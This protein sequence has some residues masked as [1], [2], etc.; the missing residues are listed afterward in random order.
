MELFELY[1]TTGTIAGFALW[2][3]EV[4]EKTIRSLKDSVILGGKTAYDDIEILDDDEI[5]KNVPMGV[6]V[7]TL[8]VF[9]L[10]EEAAEVKTKKELIALLNEPARK[11]LSFLIKTREE[12]NKFIGQYVNMSDNDLVR[13]SVGCGVFMCDLNK[14]VEEYNEAERLKKQFAPKEA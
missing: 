6:L 5:S 12:M 10:N 8:T 3:V 9:D 4:T 13:L 1:P 11:I 7:V 2:N 14:A